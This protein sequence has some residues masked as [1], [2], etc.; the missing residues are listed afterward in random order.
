MITLNFLS[1]Q[2]LFYSFERCEDLDPLRDSV[3]E[4]VDGALEQTDDG[5]GGEG[6]LRGY[7]VAEEDEGEV[8]RGK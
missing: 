3:W 2:K 4:G 5:H 7:L 8:C 1:K 6:N